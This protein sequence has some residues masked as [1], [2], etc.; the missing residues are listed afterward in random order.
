MKKLFI[1]KHYFVAKT[2]NQSLNQPEAKA[3]IS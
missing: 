1:F 2:E 3:E